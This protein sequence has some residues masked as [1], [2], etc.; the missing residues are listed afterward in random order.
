M[1]TH[2]IESRVR[3]H[4]R[5]PDVALRQLRWLVGGFALGFLIPF[6]FA[7]RL[8]LSR[9]LYYGI[10]AAS[11]FGFFVLWAKATEQ[12]LGG[13]VRRRWGLALVLGLAVAAVLAFMVVHVESAT[14]RPGGLELAGAVAWRGLVYGAADGLLLSAFPI[15]AVF[16]AFAG[17]R[18]RT[19]LWGNVLIGIVALAASLVMTATYH[20]GYS[21]FRSA[22]LRSPVAGDVAWSI[23]TLVTLNPIGAP[24]AHAGLHVSAVLHS[25]DTELFLPPHE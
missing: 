9:D 5:L 16:A 4:H 17:N 8:G 22:K 19:R 7:D 11:A 20:V 23:P 15:L 25:Y 14:T 24:I 18:L 21:D 12:S 1:S 10:Y 2:T 6:V 13:M 3:T